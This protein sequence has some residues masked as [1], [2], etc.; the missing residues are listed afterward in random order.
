MEATTNFFTSFMYAI[1]LCQSIK[2]IFANQIG[3]FLFGIFRE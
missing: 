2:I 1:R 3:S